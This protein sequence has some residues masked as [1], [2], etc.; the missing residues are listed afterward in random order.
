VITTGEQRYRLT[1]DFIDR[2]VESRIAEAIERGELD[3]GPLKGKPIP[4]I[5]EQRQQGWWADQFVRRERSR[6]AR[7]A[8]LEQIATWRSSFWRATTIG[9]LRRAVAEANRQ[10]DRTNGRLVPEDAV[11]RFDLVGVERTWRSLHGN[12]P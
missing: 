4:D 5:D 11:P 8:A 6:L 12:R 10:I 7:D 2:L 3:P 1:V 9:E